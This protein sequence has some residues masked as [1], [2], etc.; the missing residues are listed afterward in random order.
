MLV[1]FFLW[2]EDLNIKIIFN[3]IFKIKTIKKIFKILKTKTIQ[4]AHALIFFDCSIVPMLLFICHSISGG[5]RK[6]PLI[7]KIAKGLFPLQI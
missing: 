7:L 3:G 4:I 5:R 6:Q 1:H 2:G